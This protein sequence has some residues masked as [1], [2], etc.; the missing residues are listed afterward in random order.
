MLFLSTR[1]TPLLT[2]ETAVRD[3]CVMAAKQCLTHACACAAHG[4]CS[5]VNQQWREPHGRRY[6]LEWCNKKDRSKPAEYACLTLM[7]DASWIMCTRLL[8]KIGHM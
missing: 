8:F 2:C 6:C 5:R 1:A 3:F 4:V 7:S